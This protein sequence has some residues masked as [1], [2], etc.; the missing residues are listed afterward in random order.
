MITAGLDIGS[1]T[2]KVVIYDTETNTILDWSYVATG[3]NP[4]L[5]AQKLYKDILEKNKLE[6]A[7][8]VVATGYGRK[9]VDFK[10]QISSEIICHAKGISFLK[11]EIRTIIDIGGQDSK[12]ICVDDNMKVADFVMNDKCAA[13]TGRFLEVASTILETTV[14]K[15]SAL[16]DKAD[17]DIEINSTC[18]VFAE[19]EIIGMIAKGYSVETIVKAVHLSIAKRIVN[20]VNSLPWKSPVAFTGG[21]SFNNSLKSI[22]SNLLGENMYTYNTPIITGALGAAILG[23]EKLI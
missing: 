5:T 22:I 19:S 23:K 17:E 7:D 10:N 11:P 15:L 16:A 3:V 12:V 18:V 6:K 9:I 4:T 2:S 21:V 14:D 13:G 8:Y 1:T 20:Q